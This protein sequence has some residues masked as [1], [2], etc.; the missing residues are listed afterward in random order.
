MNSLVGGFNQPIW[1]ICSSNWMISPGFGVKIKHVWNHHLDSG[2]PSL[3]KIRSLYSI[4]YIP[5]IYS[6]TQSVTVA[7]VRLSSGFP[8]WKISMSSWNPGGDEPTSWHQPTPPPLALTSDRTRCVKFLPE[9]N[10]IE[11]Q[12]AAEYAVEAP[13]SIR[14]DCLSSSFDLLKKTYGCFRE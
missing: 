2:E 10:A 3:T 9:K 12:R 11:L 4:W 13:G 14:H 1:K 7:F 8:S 6:P 5:W